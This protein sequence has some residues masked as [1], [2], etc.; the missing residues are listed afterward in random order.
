MKFKTIDP[1]EMPG[2]DEF[3]S[4]LGVL[5]PAYSFVKAG[6][7]FDVELYRIYVE[8][9]GEPRI[10][11]DVA[12]N[13]LRDIAQNTH[14]S[15]A[16]YTRGLVRK[17]DNAINFNQFGVPKASLNAP[18][19]F[20]RRCPSSVILS[21]SSATADGEPKDPRLYFVEVSRSNK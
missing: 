7:E 15:G 18:F 2:I 3:K 10:P 5:L 14:E 17:L 4:R 20:I 21:E 13:L 8:A 11:V 6:R 16:G 12:E 19:C 1:L 9:A